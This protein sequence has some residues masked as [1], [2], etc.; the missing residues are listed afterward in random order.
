MLSV[1]AA[2]GIQVYEYQ[3]FNHDVN[4]TK[5]YCTEYAQSVLVQQDCSNAWSSYS[6]ARTHFNPAAESG[7]VDADSVCSS[8]FL[9]SL[10]L[11]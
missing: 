10:A 7:T 2:W 1:F 11:A 3:T 4:M 8:F 9:P 6:L 5:C